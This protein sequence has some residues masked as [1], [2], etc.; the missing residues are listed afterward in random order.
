MRKHLVIYL[1]VSSL[2]VLVMEAQISGGA[3]IRFLDMK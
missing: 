2:S 3:G 1:I